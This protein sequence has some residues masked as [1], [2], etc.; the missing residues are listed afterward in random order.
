MSSKWCLQQ[1]VHVWSCR[2]L[3]CTRSTVCHR[4]VEPLVTVTVADRWSIVLMM[5]YSRTVAACLYALQALTVLPARISCRLMMALMSDA[6]KTCVRALGTYVPSCT[7]K[8]AKLFFMLE[9]C[10]PQRAT[11]YVAAPEPTSARR[12]VPEPQTTWQRRSPPQPGDV[13]R[14]HRTHESVVAHLRRK[15]RSEAIGHVAARGCTSWYFFLTW[16]LC[17]WYL[18][19]KVPTVN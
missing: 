7:C 6:L 1:R 9:S 11:W 8:S 14:S 2:M 4:A 12:W 15:A 5:H 13:V 3:R 19:C 17:V 16:S 18:I 10:D